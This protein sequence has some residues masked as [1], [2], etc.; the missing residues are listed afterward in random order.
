MSPNDPNDVFST[1]V[2]K[3]HEQL[4]NELDSINV[5]DLKSEGLRISLGGKTFTFKDVE[6]V[7]DES[8]EDRIRNEFRDKLNTQQQRIREKINAKINQ[9]LV[10]HQQK[11]REL[12]RKEEQMK[13]KF[14]ETAKMP[15]LDESFIGRG[16]SVVKGRSNNSLVWIYRGEFNPRFIIHYPNNSV[17]DRNKVKKPIPKRLVNKM[18]QPM[19]ILVRTKD[20]NVRSV[21]TRTIKGNN[22][23]P[24]YH[25]QT[26]QDCWGNW[27]H[28]NS[29]RTPNDILQIAKTAESILETIN[30]GSLAERNPT[31]LP[32]I[33]TIIK[34]ID[35]V[36]PVDE[37][38]IKATS[39]RDLRRRNDDSADEDI[40]SSL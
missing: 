9:L 25:Q 31:G 28:P 18:K 8:V 2:N 20:S 36:D 37:E 16:L 40:W 11:Q 39:G 32:R 1:E 34:A 4:I 14:A 13:K 3:R 12:D 33:D 10:M 30:Q 29:W 38:I 19:L 17:S 35:D 24:H 21:A 27:N 7:A 5:D 23:F 22:P 6:V 15:D 26:T